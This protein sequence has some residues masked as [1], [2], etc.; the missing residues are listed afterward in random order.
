[1]TD[2]NEPQTETPVEAQ[3]EEPQIETPEEEPSAEAPEDPQDEV[4]EAEPQ[5]AP[6][7]EYPV[8]DGDFLRLGPEIFTKVGDHSII[9]WK[10]V[11]YELQAAKTEPKQLKEYTSGEKVEVL[12]D[13]DWI[14]GMV[15]GIEKRLNLVYVHTS[16]GP[17]TAARADC[18]RPRVE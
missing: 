6:V 8:V 1:M 14:D 5:D 7:S 11:N 18:I 16:R 13:G 15:N 4:A 3:V 10:G 9:S 17:I 12:R 2:P